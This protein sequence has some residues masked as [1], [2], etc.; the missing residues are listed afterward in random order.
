MELDYFKDIEKSGLPIAEI[1][2]IQSDK[3]LFAIETSD[4]SEFLIKITKRDAKQETFFLEMY[5]TER[6]LHKIYEKYV[7]NWEYDEILIN[8]DFDIDWLVDILDIKNYRKPENII[9][10]YSELLF[11]LVFHYNPYGVLPVVTVSNYFPGLQ[12]VNRLICKLHIL[13]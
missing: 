10:Q 2:R 11:T 9:L 1:K 6:R 13:P 7:S 5:E 4:N 12:S 8:N 3:G